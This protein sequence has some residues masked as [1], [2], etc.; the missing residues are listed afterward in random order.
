MTAR[1]LVVE[2]EP[3]SR[4]ALVT[5]LSREGYAVEA[6][7]TAEEASELLA[8]SDVDLLVADWDLPGRS[9][10]RWPPSTRAAR[11]PPPSSS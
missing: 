1:I 11:R 4:E 10:P 9:G 3:D 5:L 6:A 2:D 7:S 8:A